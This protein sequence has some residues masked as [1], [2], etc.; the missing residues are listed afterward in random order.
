[1]ESIVGLSLG[2]MTGLSDSSDIEFN[3]IQI[4]VAVVSESMTTHDPPDENTEFHPDTGIRLCKVCRQEIT[5]A[6]SRM[7]YAKV[8]GKCYLKHRADERKRK[9]LK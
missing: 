8:C 2:I 7:L 4:S 5:L 9:G 1:M 3:R 6:N